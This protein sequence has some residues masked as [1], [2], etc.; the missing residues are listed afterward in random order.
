[1]RS[2][3]L[4][5]LSLCWLSCSGAASDRARAAD[6]I[7]VEGQV[8]VRGN[9]PLTVVM[10]ETDQQNLYILALDDAERRVLEPNLPTYYRIT[11]RLFADTW[12]GRLFAH[13][14]PTSM[15]KL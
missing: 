2:L 11:G 12:N 6:V 13:L 8:T 9:T 7:T 15:E 14:S 5:L 3:L 10:L 4:L 1:M